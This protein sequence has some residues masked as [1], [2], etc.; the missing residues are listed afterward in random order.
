MGVGVG[1]GVGMGVLPVQRGRL[2]LRGPV[3]R[4]RWLQTVLKAFSP[5]L[6]FRVQ[7]LEFSVQDFG[8]GI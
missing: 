6:G 7:G 3:A 1:V 4:F 5:G 8:F 2:Q